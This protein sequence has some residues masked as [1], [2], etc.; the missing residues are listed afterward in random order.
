MEYRYQSEKLSAARRSLMLPH[1]SGE[2]LSI[3]D[4]LH[5]CQMAFHRLEDS[6]LDDNEARLVRKIKTFMDTSELDDP[7][8]E[9]TYVVKARA[10]SN[11]QKLDLTNSIDELAS[12]FNLK[13]WQDDKGQ[14]EP[15]IV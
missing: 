2:A 9:G 14:T 11:A 1:S 7:N 5:N 8:G 15:A 6:R 3:A 12:S 4:A 10:L 13:F